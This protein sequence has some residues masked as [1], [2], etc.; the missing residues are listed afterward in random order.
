[1]TTP[2]PQYQP[3]SGPAPAQ[4]KN[5]LGTAALVLG[6]VGAVFAF[7]P[8]VGIFIAIPLAVLAVIFGV[9]GLVRASRTTATNKG[10][11]LSGAILGGVAL[12]VTIAMS[13][14]VFTAADQAINDT[15]IAQQGPQ[16]NGQGQ[17]QQQNDDPADTSAS[18]TA[19]DDVEISDCQVTDDMF[20]RATV[21]I[22]N[23][24]DL[25]TTYDVEIAVRGD[26]GTRYGSILVMSS[27][28]APGESETLG[29]FEV[30][31]NAN[32]NAEPGPAECEVMTASRW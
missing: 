17:G 9:I 15:P 4:P 8:V 14:L 31:G 23:S 27:T 24:T 28:L 2:P 1:M 25:A 11:A 22:T 19:A 7:I 21:T 6:I 26:D 10:P 5:G 13:T 12:V 20:T 16:S 32:P 18:G 29:G 3:Y 30:E